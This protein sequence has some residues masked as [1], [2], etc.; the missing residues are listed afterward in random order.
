MGKF[1]TEGPVSVNSF[2]NFIKDNTAQQQGQSLKKA[3]NS[4]RDG[5]TFLPQGDFIDP[6]ALS[7]SYGAEA[8]FRFFVNNDGNGVPHYRSSRARQLSGHFYSE[9]K[10]YMELGGVK[11]PMVFP[12]VNYIYDAYLNASGNNV[13]GLGNSTYRAVE[14]KLYHSNTSTVVD[15]T[16]IFDGSGHERLTENVE[17]QYLNGSAIAGPT[18]VRIY[19]DEDSVWESLQVGDR[20]VVDYLTAPNTNN[21]FPYTVESIQSGSFYDSSN[22]KTRYYLTAY[23]EEDIV[24]PAGSN[25]LANILRVTQEGSYVAD[26]SDYDNANISEGSD[27]SYV[28]DPW[29]TYRAKTYYSN[30]FDDMIFPE[31]TAFQKSGALYLIFNAINGDGLYT[32][33]VNYGSW[34]FFG[35]WVRWMAIPEHIGWVPKIYFATVTIGSIIVRYPRISWVPNYIS[36]PKPYWPATTGDGHLFWVYL[37]DKSKSANGRPHPSV[38]GLYDEITFGVTRSTD[39]KDFNPNESFNWMWFAPSFRTRITRKEEYLYLDKLYNEIFRDDLW[40]SSL[41]YL[42]FDGSFVPSVKL[43][44]GNSDY[45]PRLKGRSSSPGDLG[46]GTIENSRLT[47]IDPGASITDVSGKSMLIESGAA[48][49]N[50]S[51]KGPA[52]GHWNGI[53]HQ[54]FMR[55]LSSYPEKVPFYLRAG[56]HGHGYVE[57]TP[58]S[59][60]R[61]HVDKIGSNYKII[62]ESQ[63]LL[64]EDYWTGEELGYDIDGDL[65][66]S[67]PSDWN[68]VRDGSLSSGLVN[69]YIKANLNEDFVD[70]GS[71]LYIYKFTAYHN[72]NVFYTYVNTVPGQK[73]VL[74]M[75]FKYKVLIYINDILF[76]AHDTGGS[77][78]DISFSFIPN[79]YQTKLSI[80]PAFSEE[81]L[82]INFTKIAQEGAQLPEEYFTKNEAIEAWKKLHYNEHDYY[83]NNSYNASESLS[84]SITW[85]PFLISY[86]S[87]SAQPFFSSNLY[88]LNLLDQTIEETFIASKQTEFLAQFFIKKLDGT[89]AIAQK[90]IKAF[91][92]APAKFTNPNATNNQ[93]NKISVED[94]FFRSISD[95][96]RLKLELSGTEETEDKEIHAI[97]YTSETDTTVNKIDLYVITDG[98]YEEDDLICLFE[99]SRDEEN[100]H[101]IHQQSMPPAGQDRQEVLSAID[102]TVSVNA[103]TNIVSGSGTNFI[104][105]GVGA[106]DRI[107]IGGETFFIQNVNSATELIL[108]GV[109][110]LGATNVTAE[111]GHYKYNPI[112]EIFPGD[113]AFPP[114]P[115]TTTNQYTHYRVRW[116]AGSQSVSVLPGT[117]LAQD[118]ITCASLANNGRISV[119]LSNDNHYYRTNSDFFPADHNGNIEQRLKTLPQSDGTIFIFEGLTCLKPNIINTLPDEGVLFPDENNSKYFEAGQVIDGA[120]YHWVIHFPETL[121]KDLENITNSQLD[122]DWNVVEKPGKRIY[123]SSW[124]FVHNLRVNNYGQSWNNPGHRSYPGNANTEAYF[125]GDI[126]GPLTNRP[127]SS[128]SFLRFEA[129]RR[130]LTEYAVKPAKEGEFIIVMF[131]RGYPT[132]NLGTP[133]SVGEESNGWVY[134]LSQQKRLSGTIAINPADLYGGNKIPCYGTNSSFRREVFGFPEDATEEGL[135]DYF[136]TQDYADQFEITINSIEYLVYEIISDTELILTAK[137]TSSGDL[138]LPPLAVS[139]IVGLVDYEDTEAANFIDQNIYHILGRKQHSSNSFS[140][141]TPR[142]LGQAA[143]PNEDPNSEVS[144]RP[145]AMA[146]AIYAYAISNNTPSSPVGGTHDFVN[147]DLNYQGSPSTL[148]VGFDLEPQSLIQPDDKNYIFAGIAY[149]EDG[150]DTNSSISWQYGGYISTQFDSAFGDDEVAGSAKIG[151]IFGPIYKNIQYMPSATIRN[152]ELTTSG[153]R[154]RMH[155]LIDLP[156][157]DRL[158]IEMAAR[159]WESVILDDIDID[160]VIMPHPTRSAG[161]TLASATPSEYIIGEDSAFHAQNRAQIKEMYVYL[162]TDDI[163]P[164]AAPDSTFVA[165]GRNG[166]VNGVVPGGNKLCHIM[167]HE[168]AHGLGIGSAWNVEFVGYYDDQYQWGFANAYGSQY[169]GPNAIR[170]YQNIVNAATQ[171]RM[172]SN[173]TKKITTES[174][175]G[176]TFHTDNVPIESLGFG[177]DFESWQDGDVSGGHVAEYAKK[178]GSTI[179]PT[180]IELM[181]PIYDIDESLISRLTLGFLED[182]GYQVN[183]SKAQAITTPLIGYTG[184]EYLKWLFY[185]AD[186]EATPYG[187]L[188]D[189]QRDSYGSL[190]AYLSEQYDSAADRLTDSKLVQCNCAKHRSHATKDPIMP[191]GISE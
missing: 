95:S 46:N 25:I 47:L 178:V 104:Y 77:F 51:G 185:N 158:Q 108:G 176:K 38:R 72:S 5:G 137:T 73:T 136:N 50:S 127:K 10:W 112:V 68:S 162:D 66:V 148:P 142:L 169:N 125:T 159:F 81:P 69:F 41:A 75:Q 12:Y 151:S 76:I 180:F 40:Y 118:Q 63:F 90:K 163:I 85:G 32:P 29:V 177:Q 1:Q 143:H 45:F 140:W 36:V 166:V 93:G 89:Q 105:D 156:M 149:S 115:D 2:I 150:S 27:H 62:E 56:D 91:P 79:S 147:E 173:S 101:L 92:A 67:T 102:G 14:S 131:K 191:Y 152:G 97:P 170:E 167:I 161:G 165:T 57:V 183:Y 100:W 44:N 37:V 49:F 171:I 129:L 20:V 61:Y 119:V 3:F 42:L 39:F 153:L 187:G 83:Y 21:T 94:D 145:L 18:Y 106:G 74:N 184:I 188:N 54:L 157:E 174:V 34:A 139:E 9:L 80:C 154:L 186:G 111:V 122:D 65:F 17:D 160:V 26:A 179:Q 22:E 71:F 4:A 99:F 88:F 121:G 172:Y 48:E 78:E 110:T 16:S 107:K 135:N 138:I 103:G 130:S 53:N 60:L 11:H 86:R 132:E 7:E 113:D 19:A 190:E 155:F 43:I 128:I 24:Y 23:V 133:N 114:F 181:T 117:I 182:L 123:Q 64:N 87:Q 134:E 109:H 59:T 58:E 33:P 96:I 30:Q 35:L 120:D 52:H 84:K 144:T 126:R 13:S 175:S 6:H 146:Q 168:I 164:G 28:L 189:Q 55:R 98:H 116:I 70:A 8:G 31:E 82:V 15:K 141:S 124:Q